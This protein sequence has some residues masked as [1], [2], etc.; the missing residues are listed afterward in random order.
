MKIH[1]AY[2][3]KMAAQLKE[4]SAQINVLEAKIDKAG[5]EIKLKHAEELVKLRA[6]QSAATKKMKE[7]ENATAEAWD[8][9]KETADKIWEDLKSGVATAHSKFK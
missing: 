6:S 9:T 1:E 7:L 4:W 2:R 8:Q 3:E 5:A